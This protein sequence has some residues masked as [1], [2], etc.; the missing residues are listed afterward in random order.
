MSD[1]KHTLNLPETEF[2]MRGNLAQRE[3]AMIKQ[4]QEKKLY[5]QIRA[6]KKG[7]K[8]FILHDGPPYANGDIHL[9]HSV[10]KILKDI[11][12]KSKTLSDFDSPY[13]PGWDCHG[14]PIELQVEKKVGKPG[15]KVSAAEFRQKCREYAQKQIDGQLAGFERLGVFGDWDNPYKTMDFTSEANII[16]A[17]GKIIDNGHLQKGAKPVHFCTDC[18]SA[19]AEAEVEYKDKVSHA[20]DIKFKAVDESALVGKFHHPEGHTGEGEVSV[21]I[22]TTTPWTIPSNQAVA[23]AADVEYVLMQV[24]GEQPQRIVVASELASDLMDKWG[25]EKFHALGYAKGGELENLVVNHPLYAKQVPLI[26]GDHVTTDAGTGCVHTAPDHGLEDFDVG[27]KYGIEPIR[28]VGANGVYNEEVELFAGQHIFK[29]N[30]NIIE[31]LQE[32]GALL[33]HTKIEHSYAHCWRH[34]TPIIYRA[35]PQWF[36]SMDKAELR[37]KSLAEIEKV[38][39]L[40]EWGQGRIEGMVEGRPDWCISRQRTWGVPITLF[41]HNETDELHPNSMEI[42]EKVAKEVETK[43]IQAWW[44]IDSTELLGEEASQ[45]RKVEDTLDVWFD[46]GVTHHFVVDAREEFDK[47]ADLYLEGSDQ[48]RGW[49]MSSLMTSVAMNN[50][51]PYNQVLTHGFTVDQN[52]HKMSKSLGNVVSPKDVTGKFGADI[53]RLWVASTDYTGEMTVSDE[54][55]KRSADTYRRIRNTSRFL[56]ANLSGFNPAT[57]AV[58]T[59]EMV[60]LDRWIV[61]KAARLQQEI[62]AA[63]DKYQF[64]VVMQKLMNFCSVDLGSFYLDVIKDRQYTAKADSNAR[65]SCQTAL[66]HIAEAMT[67]WM[68][69]VLSFTAQEIWSAL[70]GERDEFVFTGV[71]YTD[72]EQYAEQGELGDD[73]WSQV[74]AVKEQVN[75]ALEGLKKDKVVGGSLEAEVT[76]YAADEILQVVNKLEDELRFVLITSVAEV[77][78]FSESAGNDSLID[79]DIDGLVLS[80]K[81]S[82]DKKCERCWHYSDT[83]GQNEKHEELCSRCVE[84]VDGQGETRKFA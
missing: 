41:I 40:P 56:L 84:N 79:T 80:I 70:P 24:E 50:V 60:A 19:L 67:C 11:I 2:P 35:T 36:V 15:K 21:V 65:R 29:A 74:L 68:A 44:D 54:I 14:L 66:Y 46:S 17:L 82:E 58:A 69:P 64:H 37:S 55:F 33:K 20:I 39:W 47:A 48:H 1:Y 8:S 72:I 25:F 73:Y 16:R 7:K 32:K 13:V 43:G 81:A 42:L 22:W 28:Y 49:F 76:L 31:V 78:P 5:Q 27:A 23:L 4:W 6:A 53:L 12:V 30:E 3:P 10:N 77:K 26:L 59:D 9:G 83:V 62:I 34:K 45:Y 71:W 52:G 61:G 18:G 51:A 63:Y 57:D 75:R 38:E